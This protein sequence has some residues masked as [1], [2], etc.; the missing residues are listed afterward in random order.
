MDR[1]SPVALMPE[2]QLHRLHPMCS[3]P[4]RVSP[5]IPLISAFLL[6][7]PVR[8]EDTPQPLIARVELRLSMVSHRMHIP[9]RVN[10]YNSFGNPLGNQHYAVPNLVFEPLVTLYNPH[11]VAISVDRT[12]VRLENPPVGFKFQKNDD[13]L[14]NEWSNGG[15][16]V[17]IARLNIN[18]QQDPDARKTFT[19]TLGGGTASDYA[20]SPIVLE[21]GQAK[22]FAARV[23]S[24]WTWGLETSGGIHPRSFAD[25]Y[26]ENDFTNRDGRTGNTFGA[27]FIP[28]PA[29][30]FQYDPRAG[31]QNDH[32]SSTTDRPAATKY[33]FEASSWDT[34]W[35]AIKL[36]DDVTVSAEVMRTFTGTAEEPDF[37][38]LDLRNEVVDVTQDLRAAYDFDVDRT[39]RPGGSGVIRRRF[40]VGDIL[41]TPTD[42][43][44]GGKSPFANFVIT[45]RS[46]ALRTGRFL[47]ND[48][49]PEELYETRLEQVIDFHTTFAGN[50][51]DAPGAGVI[52][53]YK[54]AREGNLLYIDFAAKPRRSTPW[55][56]KG[57]ADLAAG[58]TD[59]LASPGNGV[60][61]GPPGAGIYKARIDISGKGAKYFVRIEE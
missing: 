55:G 52:E 44:P 5:Q 31:F 57:T 42:S 10:F 13:Y 16:A 14:R 27:E 33:S 45:A 15:A 37:R 40:L 41:Q 11:N 3:L 25:W 9:D 19:M 30:L 4:R 29:P 54:V 1:Y 36:T 60:T 8:A 50:P 22:Q 34:G 47:R 46:K 53:V 38:M 58:F 26:S 59:D 32:L 17:G 12:R 24:N 28:S 51:S 56:L 39:V 48:I 21:P 23:E 61:E 49:S 18:D 35:V 20:S 6:S 2:R 43:T 7:L